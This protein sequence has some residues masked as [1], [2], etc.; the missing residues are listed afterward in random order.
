MQG[1]IQHEP[2]R[3]AVAAKSWTDDPD[4]PGRELAEDRVVR[5]V[6]DG[7]R[8]D[9]RHRCGH[10][11]GAFRGED[12]IDRVRHQEPDQPGARPRGRGGTEIRGPG[13]AEASGQHHGGAEGALVRVPGTRRD[14]HGVRRGQHRRAGVWDLE[15]RGRDR[16][17]AVVGDAHLDLCA[18]VIAEQPRAG[19]PVRA[20]QDLDPATGKADPGAVEALDHGFLGCPATGQALVVAGAVGLFGGGVDLVQ[21]AGAGALDCE[22]DPVNRDGVYPDS[23]HGDILPSPSPLTLTLSPEGER[24]GVLFD[25]DGFREVARLVDVL[26]EL[27]CDVVGEQLKHHRI[28]DRGGRFL[29]R[30]HPEDVRR[31]AVQ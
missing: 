7:A 3:R 27:D 12:G 26:A 22:R 19:R 4:R 28:E 6:T 20:R 1:E 24:D 2:P 15:V 8:R 29:D 9:L 25:G 30:G 21:E 14:Q 16:E 5:S 11:L 23:L 31:D 13:Q 10:H 17:P 18:A